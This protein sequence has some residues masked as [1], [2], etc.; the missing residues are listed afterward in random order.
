MARTPRSQ[1]SVDGVE[2]GLWYLTFSRGKHSRVPVKKDTS[3]CGAGVAH[4]LG[5]GE[6]TGSNPVKGILNSENENRI[7]VGGRVAKGDRL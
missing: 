6:A 3:L 1:L 5:K 4:S 2:G 7:W